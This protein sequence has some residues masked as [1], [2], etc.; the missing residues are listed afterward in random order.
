MPT[1][2]SKRT[3]TDVTKMYFLSF[4]GENEWKLVVGLGKYS[5]H[6]RLSQTWGILR[7]AV[8]FPLF[9]ETLMSTFTA[10]NIVLAWQPTSSPCANAGMFDLQ[11]CLDRWSVSVCAWV[12]SCSRSPQ[13]A[14]GGGSSVE[15]RTQTPHGVDFVLKK[16]SSRNLR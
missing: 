9:L 14:G 11:R 2:T 13:T 10:A 3:V 7:P 15:L 8:L 1:P 4:Y 16:D 6:Q 5:P 12:P